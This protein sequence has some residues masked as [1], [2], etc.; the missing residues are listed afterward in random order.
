MRMGKGIL[1]TLI[2][3]IA[4]SATAQEGELGDLVIKLICLIGQILPA[5][6]ALLFIIGGILFILPEKKNIGKELIKNSL[7]A[8][9]IFILISFIA[10][11]NAPEVDFL[12]CWGGGEI[13]IYPKPPVTLPNRAPIADARVGYVPIPLPDKK[14]I[15]TGIGISMYFDGSRSMD[16]DGS[17]ED[18]FWDFDDG[19]KANG[20]SVTHIYPINGEFNVQLTVWDDDLAYSRSRVRVII[21]PLEAH[22]LQPKNKEEFVNLP[23]TNITFIGIGKYGVPCDIPASPY[24]YSWTYESGFLSS[25]QNF[26]IN[27]STM[28]I[29]N[30]T[31]NLTVTDCIGNNATASVTIRIVPPKP[32]KAKIIKPATNTCFGYGLGVNITFDGKGIDGVPCPTPLPYN[33]TWTSSIDGLLSTNKIF[34]INTNN[35]SKGN[36][37]IN[38]TVTDCFGATASDIRIINIV[39]SPE[40]NIILP[41]INNTIMNCTDKFKGNASKGIP[42]YQVKWIANGTV[43]DTGSIL[44]EGGTHETSNRPGSGIYNITFEVKDSCGLNDTDSRENINVSCKIEKIYHIVFVPLKYAPGDSALFRSNAKAAYDRFLQV[45]PFK[46]CPDPESRVE[47]HVIEPKDCP[48]GC[49]D[50]CSDCQTAVAN[51]VA[52]SNFSTIWDVRV[53]L[54]KGNSCRGACGCAGIGTRLSVSNFAPCGAPPE[55]VVSHEMGHS[56]GLYHVRGPLGVNGCWDREGGACIGPNAA[57]CSEPAGER[58]LFIMPYCPTMAK[59]GPAGYNFLKNTVFRSYMGGCA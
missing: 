27:S 47:Y 38:F 24:T 23:W 35:L 2:L 16:F 58:S 31:I 43:F 21:K 55:R 39:D 3:L 56:Y 33:Y 5:I 30:Y 8:L 36:H 50:I 41:P 26:T 15:Y 6:L 22:I 34:T 18:Y 53:A 13:P 54:C 4:R 32:L 42:S 52:S 40:A 9:G 10:T 25:S 44:V 51:C 59:Y 57:D 49:S 12:G 19:A 17:I 1:L 20:V 11:L 45:S 7:I 28:G 48:S 14:E 46:D 37:T 29:G